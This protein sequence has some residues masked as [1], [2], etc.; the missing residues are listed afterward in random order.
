MSS[1]LKH[2]DFEVPSFGEFAQ[3]RLAKL[4]LR[5]EV[6]ADN[7]V[8]YW[9]FGEASGTVASDESAKANDGAYLPNSGGVWTGGVLGATGLIVN[10]SDTAID[11]NVGFSQFTQLR[12][13]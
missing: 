8:G 9:R 3:G 10:D 1:I 5:S 13:A 4:G 7:P 2:V 6:L 11:L 12:K